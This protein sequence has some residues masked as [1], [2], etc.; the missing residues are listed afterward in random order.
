MAA[1]AAIAKAVVDILTHPVPSAVAM[2]ETKRGNAD[3]EAPPPSPHRDMLHI[4]AVM[5]DVPL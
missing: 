2:R 1:T 5:I 4:T 3:R